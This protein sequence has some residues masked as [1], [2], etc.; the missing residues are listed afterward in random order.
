MKKTLLF[1]LA[2]LGMLSNAAQAATLARL[3]LL[4]SSVSPA[5]LTS[6]PTLPLASSRA[7]PGLPAANLSTILLPRGDRPPLSLTGLL[8]SLM[9]NPDA[10]RIPVLVV[11]G[12]ASVLTKGNNVIVGAIKVIGPPQ[13]PRDDFNIPKL[14]V[15]GVAAVLTRG[16]NVIV[17]A[18]KV[19]GPPQPPRND[20]PAR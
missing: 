2:A 15:S 5:A 9:P 18:I 12:I 1:A 13:P 7:L 17:G 10:P 3:P 16:N 6:L 14:V 20:P 8:P 4:T 19:I 11:S